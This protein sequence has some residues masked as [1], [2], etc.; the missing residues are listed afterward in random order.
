M[1]QA[2]SE[3]V[4]EETTRYYH[5][6]TRCVRRAFL[7]GDDAYT[8]KDFD[9]RRGWIV[10]RLRLLTSVFAIDV[11]AYTVMANYLHL[12]AQLSSE[13]AA[14]RSAGEVVER[15]GKLYPM[16]KANYEKQDSRSV[17]R[18]RRSG[19]SGLGV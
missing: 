14:A 3:Q 16:A 15:F 17:Q 2:R 12:V 8:G 9:H 18:R 4:D 5:C 13:E 11:L 10:E 7:C 1:T 6:I 19:G